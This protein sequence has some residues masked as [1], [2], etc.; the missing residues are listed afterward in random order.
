MQLLLKTKV[1]HTQYWI[2]IANCDRN[3]YLDYLVFQSYMMEI[4][5]DTRH[6]HYEFNTDPLHKEY[7]SLR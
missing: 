5:L 1:H 2:T 4:I 7:I 6:P 3:K